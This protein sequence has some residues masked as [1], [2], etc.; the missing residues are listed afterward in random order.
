MS[1]PLPLGQ[2]TLLN[3]A[4][5]FAGWAKGVEVPGHVAQVTLGRRHFNRD[6]VALSRKHLIFRRESS[7]LHPAIFIQSVGKGGTWVDGVQIVGEFT[8][9]G[10]ETITFCPPG[11]GTPSSPGY[12]WTA[13]SKLIDLDEPAANVAQKIDLCGSDVEDDARYAQ[14][15]QAQLD[16]EAAQQKGSA[17]D[18]DL[19]FA[20]QLQAQADQEAEAQR[21]IDEGSDL[22]MAQ[23]LQNEFDSIGEASYK[24]IQ[25]RNEDDPGR[26]ILKQHRASI[27]RV[28]NRQVTLPGV[29]IH[30]V[31]GLESR[32]CVQPVSVQVSPNEHSEPG[33]PLYER[34]LGAWCDVPDKTV[35]I[36][37][38]GADCAA[39]C[40]SGDSGCCCD[41]RHTRGKC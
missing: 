36:V 25:Q 5:G 12:R 10:G 1:A 39:N 24:D 18:S 16:S 38:H 40:C 17:E 9:R 13:Q 20:Q 32:Q 21:G 35:R 27:H 11:G 6:S 34:F 7:N 2:L 31:R 19:A 29:Q 28:L 14:Q 37:F 8:L 41:D 22:A 26:D 23:Q 30:K 3:L 4:A 15:L 33:T